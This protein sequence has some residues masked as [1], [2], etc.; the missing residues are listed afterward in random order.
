MKSPCVKICRLNEDRVCIGCGR[1]SQEIT[2]WSRFTDLDRM[3]RT[4]DAQLRLM[5]LRKQ[6]IK[7]KG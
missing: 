5:E 1:T 2:M 4:M 7:L 6:S 3:Q